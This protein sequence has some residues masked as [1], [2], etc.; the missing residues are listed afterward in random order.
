[1]GYRI[2]FWSGARKRNLLLI[3]SRASSLHIE[4]HLS[5]PGL[6][7]LTDSGKTT[8]YLFSRQVLGHQIRRV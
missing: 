1:M 7:P 8:I 6:M 2:D 3:Q 5:S 4:A